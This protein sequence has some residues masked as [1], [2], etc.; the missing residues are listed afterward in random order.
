[1]AQSGIIQI[2]VPLLTNW[3]MFRKN[4]PDQVEGDDFGKGDPK[5]AE[6]KSLM[7]MLTYIRGKNKRN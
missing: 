3:L 7:K 6:K 4:P 5:E 1:M 2:I